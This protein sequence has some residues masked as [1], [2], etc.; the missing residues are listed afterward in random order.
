MVILELGL[1][2]N[3]Q[4]V[5]DKQ[6]N[7]FNKFALEKLLEQFCIRYGRDSLL[8]QTVF[9]MLQTDDTIRHDPIK[10]KERLPRFDEVRNFLQSQRN[11][12]LPFQSQNQPSNIIVEK[13][14]FVENPLTRPPTDR[15]GLPGTQLYGPPERISQNDS[16]MPYNEPAFGGSPSQQGFRNPQ[17]PISNIPSQLNFDQYDYTIPTANAQMTANDS[18]VNRPRGQYSRLN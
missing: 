8:S 15:I 12:P 3:V 6:N 17:S 10:L 7:K 2:V 5:Y 4:T 13:Q 18:G 16:R 14:S 9:I 11:I 1:L